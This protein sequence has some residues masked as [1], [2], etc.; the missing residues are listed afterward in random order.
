MLCIGL[1]GVTILAGCQEEPELG[2]GTVVG[3]DPRVA[4]VEE[5]HMLSLTETEQQLYDQFK[6]GFDNQVL[7]EADPI[8]ITKLY[9]HAL[10]S[11]DY[12]TEY[13]LYIEDQEYVM[14]SKEEHL[15][16]KKDEVDR[17]KILAHFKDLNEGKFHEVDAQSGF[18]EFPLEGEK[19]GSFHLRK[20][21]EGIWKVKFMPIQ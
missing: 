12:E 3:N 9:L 2:T 7:K 6:N 14:W 20:N 15:Q 8:T 21:Q 10:K 1:L 11:K 16:Q 17:E 18:V 4:L 5:T 19:T 13:E